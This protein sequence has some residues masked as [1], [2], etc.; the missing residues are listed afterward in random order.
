M[1]NARGAR[2]QNSSSTGGEYTNERSDRTI[3]PS[4]Y[5]TSLRYDEVELWRLDHS[6]GQRSTN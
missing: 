4:A 6:A 5:L 3:G 1:W 2:T